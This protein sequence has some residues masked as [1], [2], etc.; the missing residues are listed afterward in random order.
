MEGSFELLGPLDLLQLIARGGKKGVFQTVARSGKGQVHLHGP[1]VLH[2]EW[3]GRVGDEAMMEILLLKEGRFRFIDGA[4]AETVT[5]EQ[6]LDHYL[7]Q[8]I[9]RL[10][11]R[12]EVGP[13]DLV[14]FGKGSRVSHL[15]LSPEELDLFTHLSRPIS[16]LDLAVASG[17]TLAEVLTVMGH[18]ARLGVV[19][20]ERRAPHTAKLTLA[21]R[22]PLPPFAHV[23][24]LLLRA[25]KL[26]YGRFDEVFVRTGGRTLT[27]PVRGAEDLGG[28]LL[29]PTEQLILHEL[30]AGQTVM[31]WP[32]LPSPQSQAAI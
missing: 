23:D 20:I 27:L 5:L 11:D 25:W 15:T 28:H 26:H 16:A 2:A 17:R 18:L 6:P 21:I 8:A 12:V 30:V 13:F 1:R 14:Q 22:D 24:D 10:D 32:A 9:R 29:L 19:E 7:L 3:N 31:V 4:E